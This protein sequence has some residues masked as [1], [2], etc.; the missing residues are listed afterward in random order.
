VV[1]S[2]DTAILNQASV[3]AE[4]PCVQTAVARY[5]NISVQKPTGVAFHTLAGETGVSAS[6]AA[7]VERMADG[8]PEHFVPLLERL[9]ASGKEWLAG[10]TPEAG[11][12]AFFGINDLAVT[13]TRSLRFACRCSKERVTSM[14]RAL[15]PS[16]Q[17]TMADEGKGTTVY[18][19]MCGKGF[20]I[21]LETIQDILEQPS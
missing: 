10:N 11:A 5:F 12:A 18:C 3:Q 21:P 6:R 19:H 15:Y 7:L 4:A 16:E 14:L 17:Q 9:M 13:E 1:S 8:R 20:A 2:T